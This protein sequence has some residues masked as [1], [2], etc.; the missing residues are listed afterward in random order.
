MKNG[1]SLQKQHQI[2]RVCTFRLRDKS[3]IFLPP[4]HVKLGLTKYLWKRCVKKRKVCLFKA[5]FHTIREAE[6]TERNFVDRQI[7]QYQ[8]FTTKRNSIEERTWKA[9]EKVY[10]NFL[11]NEKTENYSEIVQN[12]ISTYSA[13]GFN[14]SLKLH[15]LH[16]YLDIFL[17]IWEL[18]P[19]NLTNISIRTF[20]KLKSGTVANGFQIS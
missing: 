6:L 19:M 2:R 7:T 17:K 1:R 15:F 13:V 9:F 5:K 8:D 14:T 10:R 20:P 16:S 12:L 3:K 18:S 4:L 11:D